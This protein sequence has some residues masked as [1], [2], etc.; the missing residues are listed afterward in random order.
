VSVLFA[1][2]I[3]HVKRMRHIVICGLSGCTIFSPHDLI[4]GRIFGENEK[5]T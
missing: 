4:N 2:D 5:F 3:Q 1:L